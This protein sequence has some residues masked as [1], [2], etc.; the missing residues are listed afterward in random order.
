MFSEDTTI[1]RELR[2]EILVAIKSNPVHKR[3]L[4]GNSMDG[5]ID[6]PEKTSL[7]VKV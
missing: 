4:F 5:F 7:F 6:F 2:R 3:P 1:L